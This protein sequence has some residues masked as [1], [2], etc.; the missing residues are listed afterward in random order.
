MG[1]RRCSA[2]GRM[3]GQRRGRRPV[4]PAPVVRHVAV[5]REARRPAA[6]RIDPCRADRPA[7]RRR[8]RRRDRRRRHPHR[9]RAGRA[10]ARPAAA[11]PDRRAGG[12]EA[13][14][15]HG[16]AVVAGARGELRPPAGP[17]RRR[18]GR[19]RGQAQGQ[20]RR[21]RT[22]DQPAAHAAVGAGVR[23]PRRGPVPDRADG[24]GVDP[25]GTGP[26]RDRERQALR[27]QQPGGRRR[28]PTGP[29]PV[30]ATKSTRASTS[31]RSPSCTCPSSRRRSRR[32]TRAR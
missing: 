2:A 13:G 24:R 5:T 19:Q 12:G 29:L 7:R 30:R 10:A 17:P 18:P 4:R 28:S 15:E 31:A 21:L 27:G 16:A 20:R 23:E 11:L 25:R 1:R 8:P 14:P 9:R 6:A 22:H 26:G 32:G 3:A